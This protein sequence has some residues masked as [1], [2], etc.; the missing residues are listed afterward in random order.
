MRA[1]RF[2]HVIRDGRVTAGLIAAHMQPDAHAAQDHVDRRRRQADLDGGVG[3][4]SRRSVL[5]R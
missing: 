3:T 5:E 2:R 1:V 4:R